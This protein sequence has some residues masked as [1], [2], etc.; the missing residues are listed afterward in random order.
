MFSASRMSFVEGGRLGARASVSL[1]RTDTRLRPIRPNTH[2]LAVR[3]HAVPPTFR[4]AARLRESRRHVRAAKQ[5]LTAV[6]RSV[7]RERDVTRVAGKPAQCK[8]RCRDIQS[9]SP[10]CKTRR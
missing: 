5:T 1:V 2:T 4:I 9:F 3:S 10:P 8:G 7:G 6:K